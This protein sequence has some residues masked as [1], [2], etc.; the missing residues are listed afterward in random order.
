MEPHGGALSQCWRA[1]G[2]GQPRPAVFRPQPPQ[3]GHI[4]MGFRPGT[5]PYREIKE[6]PACTGLI[7][8]PGM[9][10]SALC[11]VCTSLFCLVLGAKA[12][13]QA[14]SF[15]YFRS[16]RGGLGSLHCTQCGM[17]AEASPTVAVEWVR[18][19]SGTHALQRADLVQRFLLLLS[20][21]S[22]P[23]EPTVQIVCSR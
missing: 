3:L 4:R 21:N 10:F 5:L 18:W 13:R 12:L 7:A 19:P 15:L 11:S 6:P 8:L 9:L 17:C 1:L 23:P 20:V 2:K 16:R 14:S 22:A